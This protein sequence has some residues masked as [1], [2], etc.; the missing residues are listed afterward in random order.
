[1]SI[2]NALWEDIDGD[3]FL[4]TPEESKPFS[5]GVITEDPLSPVLEN[6]PE[7]S[8]IVSLLVGL[9]YPVADVPLMEEFGCLQEI[10][11]QQHCLAS[12]RSD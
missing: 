5:K 1:M 3:D 11:A 8:S 9:G 7:P 12:G 2:D 4:G 6:A 10:N